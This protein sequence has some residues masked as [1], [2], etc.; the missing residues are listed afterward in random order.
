[1][2]N[3][4]PKNSPIVSG[5]VFFL[6]HNNSASPPSFRS[7]KVLPLIVISWL[8]PYFFVSSISFSIA[9][10]LV[11]NSVICLGYFFINISSSIYLLE[12]YSLLA[13]FNFDIFSSNSIF[14]I[15]KGFPLAKAFK[16]L[17]DIVC[18]SVSSKFR[19]IAL[20]VIICEIKRCLLSS[21]W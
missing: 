13:S 12:R 3:S 15:I 21:N 10:N 19:Q 17:Y 5:V 1:M 9:S 6:A 20:D 18:I 8:S 4:K 16:T 11:F 7:L 2:R 14:S